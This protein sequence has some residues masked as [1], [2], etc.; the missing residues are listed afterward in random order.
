MSWAIVGAVAT[1]IVA[2]GYDI[3]TRRVPNAL[4]FGAAAAALAFFLVTGGIRGVGWSLAGWV[5]GCALFLPF[6]LVRG[7][8]AGDVKLLAAIGAWVGPPTV[9]WAALYGAIAGGVLAVAVAFAH[10]Y[11]RRAVSNVGY[12]LWYWKAVKAGP[13][14]A[15]TLAD[16]KGPRLPYAVPIAVGTVLALWLR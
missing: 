3:R 14:P 10:G 1:G 6:F 16:A 5:V 2:C 9:L 13:V 15:F 11:L 12:M 8:G 4:T 7:M